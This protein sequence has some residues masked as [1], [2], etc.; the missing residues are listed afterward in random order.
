VSSHGGKFNIP[1][2]ILGVRQ[3]VDVVA[4]N[5]DMMEYGINVVSHGGAVR[6]RCGHTRQG[7][8]QQSSIWALINSN[9][10]IYA[11]TPAFALAQHA[12]SKDWTWTDDFETWSAATI[13]NSEDYPNWHRLIEAMHYIPELD[14]LV[15]FAGNAAWVAPAAGFAGSIAFWPAGLLFNSSAVD[16][17]QMTMFADDPIFY[18]AS[19]DVCYMQPSFATNGDPPLVRVT[20]FSLFAGIPPF[21]TAWV[22]NYMTSGGIHSLDD[23]LPGETRGFTNWPRREWKLLAAGTVDV[24][25]AAV[26]VSRVEPD[27][28]HVINSDESLGPDTYNHFH[29]DY[30]FRVQ[31]PPI[32]AL[33]RATGSVELLSSIGIV[34]LDLATGAEDP[35]SGFFPSGSFEVANWADSDSTSL[36]GDVNVRTDDDWTTWYEYEGM[37]TPPGSCRRLFSRSAIVRKHYY[38]W[39]GSELWITAGSDE[40]V[41]PEEDFVCGITQASV[42]GEDYAFF[43]GSTKRMRHLNRLLE[44]WEDITNYTAAGPDTGAGAVPNGDPID[45]PWIFRPFTLGADR[46]V[47]ACNGQA[48]PQCWRP[49]Y[50]TMRMIG[51]PDFNNEF[52]GTPPPVASSMAVLNNRLMLGTLPSTIYISSPLDFDT[53]YDLFE[54]NLNDTEGDLIS[55]NEV[56]SDQVVAFKTSS[57]YHGIASLD[58]M[59]TSAPVR[60]ERVRTGIAGPCGPRAISYLPD[61]S[62]AYA[63]RDGGLYVYDGVAPRDVGR[64]IRALLRNEIDPDRYQ[65]TWTMVDP[66]RG[67]LYVFYPVGGGSGQMNTGIVTSFDGGD[68]W[69]AWQIRLPQSWF[70]V[71]GMQAYFKSGKFLGSFTNP[72]LRLLDFPDSTLGSFT[73]G[74]QFQMVMA[75]RDGTWYRQVW[76]PWEGEYTD[77]GRLINCAWA[78]GWHSPDGDLSTYSQLHELHHAASLNGVSLSVG[79]SAEQFSGGIEESVA[80]VVTDGQD[81]LKTTA[82]LSGRRFKFSYSALA[83]AAFYYAGATAVELPRGT[84]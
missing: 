17:A 40:A 44:N 80:Q 10:R 39:S 59:G 1:P 49:G 51:D 46:Y 45:N 43:M 36:V 42:V 84:R 53:G 14:L 35:I 83:D 11:V 48:Q 47:L 69:P 28:V 37:P 77:A 22:D 18:D 58:F 16:P 2:P 5:G 19:S 54:L 6:P 30:N 9:Q 61:G 20:N 23:P 12:T 63:S 38:L 70:V 56:G 64:H 50:A 26:L 8:G 73:S 27:V 71:A 75:R 74:G 21:G 66:V 82:R 62:L 13:T 72:R 31:T 3:D 29:S 25:G 81:R 79:V 32:A 68:P 55:L 57:I 78:T 65:L 24:D 34:D 76:E 15:A 4:Q 41:S 52:V 7:F 67:L 33:V 60:F